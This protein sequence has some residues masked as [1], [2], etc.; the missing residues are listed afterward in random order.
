MGWRDRGVRRSTATLMTG[1]LVDA[2][3][4]GE[5]MSRKARNGGNALARP[6]LPTA[7]KRGNLRRLSAVLLAAMVGLAAPLAVAAPAH[8][9]VVNAYHGN[10]G[11]A[12]TNSDHTRVGIDD[13]RCDNLHVW[14]EA[15]LNTSWIIYVYE[16][17][18]CRD[19]HG[20][21][22]L[23]PGERVAALRVCTEGRGCGDWVGV[24]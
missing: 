3:E 17:N 18:G 8:A 5:S 15:L 19:G 7:R 22:A 12:W 13:Q 9:H 24:D 10:R 6:V 14:A 2:S 1:M 11:H 4:E 16:P 21:S 20:A 23:L